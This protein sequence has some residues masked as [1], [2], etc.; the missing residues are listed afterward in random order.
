MDLV[1]Y[2][3]MKILL[4]MYLKLLFLLLTHLNKKKKL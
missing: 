1:G 2:Y 4:L 3:Y